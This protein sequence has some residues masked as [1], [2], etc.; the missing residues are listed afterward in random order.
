VNQTYDDAL[1][2]KETSKIVRATFTKFED[3][4]PREQGYLSYI[5]EEHASVE[6]LVEKYLP[7]LDQIHEE[8]QQALQ[9]AQP[10]PVKKS[11]GRGR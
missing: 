5:T 6:K 2:P 8:Q 10:E 1:I 9:S 4:S 7:E 11:A 3:L